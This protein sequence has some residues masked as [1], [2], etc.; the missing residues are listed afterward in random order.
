MLLDL[1]KSFLGLRTDL[2]HPGG[3]PV[4][5][6]GMIFVFPGSLS[7][8]QRI[9]LLATLDFVAGHFGNKRTATPFADQFVDLGHHVDWEDDVGP[10]AQIFWHTSSVT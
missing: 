2:A 5:Q 6:F 9:A 10:S 4:F 7:G 1:L 8:A 3:C